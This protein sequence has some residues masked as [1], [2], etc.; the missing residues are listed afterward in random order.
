MR[1]GIIQFKPQINKEDTILKVRELIKKAAENGS[2]IVVLP[3]IFNCPYDP[4]FFSINAETYPQGITINMLR[5]SAIENN[6]YLIGGSIP[7]KEGDKL[8]NTSFI[9]DP[10]GELLGRHRK[11]HLFDIDIEGKITFK[12]SNY[13]SSGNSLTV[14]DTKYCKIGVCICFDIRFPQ[15]FNL[16]ADEGAKIIFVP[17]A[18]NMVT[19]P[20]HWETL[21]KSRAMDYQI[22]MV[23][24]SPARDLSSSYIAYGNSLVCSPFGEVLKSLDENEGILYQDIDL[25]YID[26]V[27][28]ELP[29]TTSKRNDLYKVKKAP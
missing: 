16:M 24:I 18:F 23:G 10:K 1:I 2:E 15:I 4:K 25:S 29:L 20:K 3:E 12:E 17:A 5:D 6:I 27:R 22:Y 7:E 9:F 26:K 11:L 21:F 28:R 19:G 14:L 13:F 8:Y